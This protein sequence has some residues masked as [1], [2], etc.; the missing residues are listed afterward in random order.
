MS[1]NEERTVSMLAVYIELVVHLRSKSSCSF[2]FSFFSNASEVNDGV[3]VPFFGIVR[4]DV[5]T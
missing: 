4:G 1:G 2:M 3:A 5:R